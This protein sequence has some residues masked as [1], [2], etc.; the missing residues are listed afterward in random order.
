MTCVN[1][2]IGNRAKDVI[3]SHEIHS[4]WC[5]RN[6][7]YGY[8]IWTILDEQLNGASDDSSAWTRQQY[9]QVADTLVPLQR[10]RQP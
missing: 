1:C 3:D 2:L 8:K 10:N 6:S 5:S 4:Q 9:Q 7:I